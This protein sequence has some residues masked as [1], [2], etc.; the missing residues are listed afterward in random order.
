MGKFLVIAVPAVA[1]AAWVLATPPK[2]VEEDFE[3]SQFP[4]PG[5]RKSGEAIWYW[6]NAGGYAEGYAECGSFGEARASLETLLFRVNKGTAL[7]VEFLYRAYSGG[8]SEAGC[9]LIIYGRWWRSIDS[10]RLNWTKFDEFTPLFPVGGE[11]RLEFRLRV[12]GGS[13]GAMGKWFLDDVLITRD[14]VAVDPT[15]LGRVKALFR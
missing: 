3:G 11:Y 2:A 7:R 15:S 8:M 12:S 6:K 4:P 13:H 10:Y 1:L 14:N 9:Y 5:W